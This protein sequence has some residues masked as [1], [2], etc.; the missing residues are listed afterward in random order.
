[1]ESSTEYQGH[2]IEVH[3]DPYPERS[4]PRVDCDNAGT[5]C[6][7]HRRYSLGDG[8]MELLVAQLQEDAR[9]GLREMEGMP[10]PDVDNYSGIVD[11]AREW[12]YT[13]LPLYLYDHSGLTISTTPFTCLWDS[14]QVGWIFMSQKRAKEEGIDNPKSVLEAEVKEYDCYL[15]GEVYGYIVKDSEG[16]EI[17]SCWG[18]LLS[19]ED[20]VEEAKSNLPKE[21]D[22]D[23]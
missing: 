10:L 14:G 2:V 21:G 5:M 4:N 9:W 15:L 23:E 6:C 8:G 12:G 11:L 18:F 1:M 20:V 19:I 22:A 3:R 17:D 13:C 16:N 7:E